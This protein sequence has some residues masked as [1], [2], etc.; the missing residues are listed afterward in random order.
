MYAG[1]IG[2][3]HGTELLVDAAVKLA[4][5]PDM[6]FLV[7]GGGS[8]LADL[9]RLAGARGLANLR[10]LPTQPPELLPEMLASADV[11]VLTSRPGVG[12]T[13]FPGRIYNCLLAARPVVASYDADSDV[14]DL[15]QR[16][17]AGIV[18]EPGEVEGFCRALANLYND[19]ALRER[20]GQGGP[21]FMARDY[22]PQVVVEQY[23]SLLRGL[24]ETAS[25]LAAP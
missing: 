1:N 2:Y 22:S 8:K 24:A 15:L 17:G 20:L 5:I 23:D 11:L 3:T 18:T 6:L 21:E 4:T 13:A 10:F 7:I 16:A 9:E 12:Q 14:A 25:A 19:P